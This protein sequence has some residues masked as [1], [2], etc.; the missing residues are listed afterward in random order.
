M[1]IIPS[2]DRLKSCETVQGKADD[3]MSITRS[4]LASRKLITELYKRTVM[5]I[6]PSTEA[7]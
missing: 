4:I 5:S 3:N 2:T 1:S 6:T 7:L